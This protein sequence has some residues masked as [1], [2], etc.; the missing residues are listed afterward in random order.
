MEVRIE[1]HCHTKYSHDSLLSFRGL[2]LLCRLK[3]IKYIA[4]TEHNNIEGAIA[5]N[6][7][8]EL[9][10]NKVHVIVGEEIFTE[11]GE[12]IGLYL[13]DEIPP[14][15]S[16]AET[17]SLIKRQDGVVYV[18]HPYDEKRYRTVL[19]EK[20]IKN[21]RELIDCIEVHNGRNIS[22]KFSLVQDEIAERYSIKKVIGSDAHTMLEIGRNYMISGIEPNDKNSFLKMLDDKHFKKKDCLRMAHQLTRIVRVIKLFGKGNTYEILRII[23]K[24]I[25]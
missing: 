13:K 25:K 11:D 24:R 22:S 2:Y 17:I 10:G 9:R 6:R 8:C 18:P 4:I 23:N 12:I 5:F 1:L 7:F 3:K 20:E 16:L 15:L 14:N 21:N 19:P